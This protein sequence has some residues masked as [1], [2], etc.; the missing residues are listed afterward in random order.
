MPGRPE[1]AA[2]LRQGGAPD[3]RDHAQERQRQAVRHVLGHLDRMVDVLEQADQAD[4]QAE[5]Q[6][7]AQ[8][9]SASAGSA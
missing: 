5:A 4:P 2:A 9:R 3:P 1:V 8:R 6:Q 7:Q